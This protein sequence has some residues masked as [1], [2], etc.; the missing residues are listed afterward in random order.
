MINRFTFFFLLLAVGAYAQT[1]TNSSGDASITMVINQENGTFSWTSNCGAPGGPTHGGVG[2]GLSPNPDTWDGA[3]IV[4]SFSDDNAFK[5]TRSGSMALPESGTY[6]N[7][8]CATMT[9]GQSGWQ[10]EKWAHYQVP[11][12]TQ[13]CVISNPGASVEVASAFVGR[14]TGSKGGNKYNLAI[15]AGPGGGSINDVTGDYTIFGNGVGTIVWQVWISEGNGYPKSNVVETYS[16]VVQGQK[17]KSVTVTIPAGDGLHAVQYDIF[18]DGVKIGSY[19]QPGGAN[20]AIKQVWVD[21]TGGPV[22]LITTT[23]GIV[24]DGVN[25]VD[26]GDGS[27]NVTKSSLLIPH[28]NEVSNGATV[29]ASNVTS[30]PVIDSKGNVTQA[31]NP[32]AGN[33]AKNTSG[34]VWSSAGGSQTDLVTNT[35]YREG[36]GKIYQKMDE[37]IE[38]RK[39]REQERDKK[40]D[41]P[42]LDL[43]EYDATN[44]ESQLGIAVTVA[45]E[46]VEDAGDSVQSALENYGPKD[47]WKQEGANEVKAID[48]NEVLPKFTVKAGGTE[49]DADF[50]PFTNPALSLGAWSVGLAAVREL[51]LWAMA[52]A[53]VHFSCQIVD[54]KCAE[55]MIVP[56]FRNSGTKESTVPIYGQ[57]KAFL[58][59]LI[60]TTTVILFFSSIVVFI[61]SNIVSIASFTLKSFFGGA[62]AGAKAGGLVSSAFD[63]LGA[64]ALLA[65]FL[66]VFPLDAFL[67]FSILEL[68]VYM[69]AVPLFIKFAG[70]KHSLQS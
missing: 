54:R 41:I 37:E 14:A 64:N 44:R 62:G 4:M 6:I 20:A 59:S 66:R 30:V 57:S 61:N 11:S 12:G 39:A 35:V 56:S 46:K 47:D 27:G 26:S 51:I 40:M 52:Y 58:V 23:S 9:D 33:P 36:V 31:T 8:W 50:N 70:I 49:I 22:T 19:Q 68:L 3:L 38:R 5:G 29:A 2:I 42:G 34:V 7:L 13:T 1:V 67:Q 60:S 28:S 21:S 48:P 45:G 43:S 10:G 32:T 69:M 55:L 53:F 18:Q 17:K 65:F 63:A 25:I 24:R 15:V 16:T